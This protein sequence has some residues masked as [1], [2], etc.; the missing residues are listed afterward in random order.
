MFI[1]YS[2]YFVIIAY[3]AFFQISEMKKSYKFSLFLTF[4]VIFLC[5]SMMI[6][7]AYRSQNDSK[8]CFLTSLA[9]MFVAFH[10]MFNIYMYIIAY[11]YSPSVDSLEDL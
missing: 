2:S 5:I 1:L 4:A 8:L 9:V 7:N 10:A 3:V 11:L 6:L